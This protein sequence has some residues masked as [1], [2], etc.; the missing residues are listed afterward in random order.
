ML[1]KNLIEIL[2]FLGSLSNGTEGLHFVII[3]RQKLNA[4]Q[5]CV[6]QHNQVYWLS[7]F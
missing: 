5:V 7:R 1:V 3:V 2:R 6:Y 4:G